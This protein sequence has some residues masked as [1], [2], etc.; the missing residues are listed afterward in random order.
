MIV[1]TYGSDL[2]QLGLSLILTVLYRPKMN[3]II[4]L[5]VQLFDAIFLEYA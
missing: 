1:S 4:D 2:I 3:V 5:G